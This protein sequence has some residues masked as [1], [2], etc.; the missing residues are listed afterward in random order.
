LPEEF[1]E[2]YLLVEVD[3]RAE[4]IR[5][6]EE[7]IRTSVASMA[8]KEEWFLEWKAL[9]G[10]TS[11]ATVERDVLEAVLHDNPL[12]GWAAANLLRRS[13]LGSAVWNYLSGALAAFKDRREDRSKRWRI[14]HVFGMGSNELVIDELLRL[15]RTDEYRW[16]WYGAVRS[17]VEIA[18]LRPELRTRAFEAVRAVAVDLGRSARY[19]SARYELARALRIGKGRSD[20]TDLALEAIDAVRQSIQDES[21]INWDELRSEFVSAGHGT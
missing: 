2:P 12:I 1:R 4:D 8:S 10:R 9:F 18:W 21:R 6:A 19:E 11:G 13:V 7:R 3:R 20:W 14:V 15:I 17:L 5:A 16:V